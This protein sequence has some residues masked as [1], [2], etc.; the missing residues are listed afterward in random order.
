[1]A[2]NIKDVAKKAGVS[3]AT[4]SKY[5]HGKKLKEKNKTAIEDAIKELNFTV[6]EFARALRTHNNMTIGVLIP[7][8]D[9]MF[10]TSI[11]SCVENTLTRYGYSTIICDCQQD[12]DVEKKKLEFLMSK[13]VSGLIIIPYKLTNSTLEHLNIPIVLIDRII[14]TSSLSSV[15]VNNREITYDTTKYLLDRG[16]RGI[17][18]IN[19]LLDIFTAR[20]RL[21]GYTAAMMDNGISDLSG[22]IYSGDYDVLT[23]YKGV[24][25]KLRSDRNITSVI[26]CNKEITTGALMAIHELGLSIPEDISIIGFDCEDF[27]QAVRPNLTYVQQPINDIG[28]K[29]AELL[30]TKINSPDTPNQQIVLNTSLIEYRSVKALK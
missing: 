9:N 1:M 30:L 24:M 10:F 12:E 8:L 6:N 23:G 22:L 14:E 27:A 16:H 20:E 18:F 2:I 3:P 26:T 13:M 17:A 29:A 4:V 25:D 7:N 11:I 28:N 19:G 5:L 21:S 15:V